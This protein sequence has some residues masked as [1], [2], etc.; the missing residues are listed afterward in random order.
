MTTILLKDV[1]H[2]PDIGLTLVS[3]GKITTANYKVIFRGPTCRIYDCK[4]KVIGQ[5]NDKNGLYR[6]DHEV[7]VNI[8]MA[9]EDQEVLTIEELHRRMGHITLETAKQMEWSY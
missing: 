3:I 4:D 9:G 2:C 5:I 7:A 6:V 8:A 1:L